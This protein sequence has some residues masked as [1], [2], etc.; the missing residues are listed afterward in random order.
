MAFDCHV[1]GTIQRYGW[2]SGI[3]NIHS[4]SHCA[5]VTPFRGI[6][7]CISERVGANYVRINRAA[8]TNCACQVASARIACCRARISENAMAFYCH[9]VCAIERDC[10]WGR[11]N[12]IYRSCDWRGCIA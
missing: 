11:I 1:V 10:W 4:S 9:W 3:N 8:D 5:W 6:A 2:G 7:N 12:D